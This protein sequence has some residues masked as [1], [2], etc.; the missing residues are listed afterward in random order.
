MA[1]SVRNV[2]SIS[3]TKRANRGNEADSAR[4]SKVAL[5]CGARQAVELPQNSFGWPSPRELVQSGPARTRGTPPK[6]PPPR[7]LL[8]HRLN[9][10]SQIGELSPKASNIGV[11]CA[12]RIC[13]FTVVT[14]LCEM[15][16]LC[17]RVWRERPL[18]IDLTTHG[19][20]ICQALPNLW[21]Q[22]RHLPSAR[23]DVREAMDFGSQLPG[24]LDC[25]RA[26]VHELVHVTEA[27]SWGF[28]LQYRP[29]R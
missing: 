24:I 7:I 18:E 20:R 29:P 2:A 13:K 25:V 5:T 28:G 12:R 21:L 11:V 27:N 15:R 4:S 22:R 6:A 23:Q 26:Q 8:L 16:P 14:H 19:C 1:R 9:H 17:A 10:G 3:P